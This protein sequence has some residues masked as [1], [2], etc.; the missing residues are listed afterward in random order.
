[1]KEW[2]MDR[3]EVDELIAHYKS[4]KCLW[5]FQSKEYKR[6]ELK[7]AAWRH[8]ARMFGKQPFEVKMKLKHL[9][10]AY[11]A[12]KKKV[13]NS[14][15]SGRIYKPTLFYYKNFSFLDNIV[16]TR[17]GPSDPIDGDVNKHASENTLTKEE[18]YETIENISI[19]PPH[20]ITSPASSSQPALVAVSPPHETASRSVNSHL[21]IEKQKS[22]SKS[23]SY[24]SRLDAAVNILEK[25]ANTTS[26]ESIYEAFGKTVAL[27]LSQLPPLEATTTMSEIYQAL[28]SNIIKSLLSKNG[29]SL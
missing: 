14:L 13:D 6:H 20:S 7:K 19:T 22:T 25:V 5:D 4:Y 23:T 12:E 15:A 2:R 1:M 21:N 27:Q 16:I 11:V 10:S 9:R 18:A 8:L 3:D 17:K 28:S 29:R 26:D 24:Y